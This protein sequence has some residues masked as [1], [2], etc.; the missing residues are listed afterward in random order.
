MIIL[1][2]L[3][4]LTRHLS[5]NAALGALTLLA[6]CADTGAGP[7]TEASLPPPSA[8]ASDDPE[9]AT[10]SPLII[11]P[12]GSIVLEGWLWGQMNT[13]PEGSSPTPGGLGGGALPP[14]SDYG[15]P[16]P[17]ATTTVENTGPDGNYTVYRPAAL[18][19]N[20]F[21]HPIATWGNGIITDP[22]FYPELLG[23]IASHG[24]VIVA[25]NSSTVY[26][27][28][29]TAGLD[30]L[31]AQNSAPGVYQGKLDPSR[32]VSIGYSLGGGAAVDAGSHPNVIATISFHGLQGAAERLRGPLLLFTGTSDWFVSADAFVTPTYERSRVQTFYATLTGAGHLYPLGDAGDERAPAIAWLRLWVYG[33]QGARAYFYGDNCRLCQSPW[34]TPQRKNWR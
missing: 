13:C 18:G 2:D 6:A 3:Q 30:W 16:G 29:L 21:R 23:T 4:R 24:F 17:F 28:L 34:V 10:T 22:S 14:V 12:D 27:E 11:C 7:S 33:D 25:S 31:I 15:A 8:V 26:A 1:P 5:A 20:G 32:A 19:N 9:L